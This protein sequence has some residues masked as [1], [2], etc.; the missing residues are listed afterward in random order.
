M[1]FEEFITCGVNQAMNLSEFDI[2]QDMKRPITHYWIASSHNTYL[3]GHQL[4]G[5]S[6]TEQYISVLKQ[7]CRCVE[8]DCWDGDG[9]E[10]IIYHGTPSTNCLPLV[11]VV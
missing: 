4:T 1:E 11:C 9:G 2:T 6:S 3:E 5:T 10:P 7:G 8:L